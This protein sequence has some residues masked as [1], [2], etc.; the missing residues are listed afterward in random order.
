MKKLSFKRLLIVSDKEKIAREERLET[1]EI[2]V[3]SQGVNRTGK[4]SFIKSLYAALGADPQR[5]NAKWEELQVKLL[6]EFSIDNISYFALR[7]GRHLAFFDANQSLIASYN[8]VT[9]ASEFWGKVFDAEISLPGARGDLIPPMPAA[10]FMPFYIDQDTGLSDTW[11]SFDGLAAYKSYKTTLV[12]FH[13]GAKPKEYYLA[14][15]QKSASA[16]ELKERENEHAHLAF[17]QSKLGGRTIDSDIS[18]NPVDFE[19]QI[20][21]FL[22]QQNA[23]NKLREGVRQE[24]Y[25]L[26]GERRKLAQE[27]SLAAATLKE[28]DADVAYLQ[29]ID[30]SEIVCPTCNTVHETSFANTLRLSADA[31]T[32]RDYLIRTKEQITKVDANIEKKSQTLRRYD[33]EIESIQDILNE[34]RGELSLRSLLEHESRKIAGETLE[35]EKR[36]IEGEIGRIGLAI[37]EVEKSMRKISGT[38]RRKEIIDFYQKKLIEFCQDLNLPSPTVKALSSLRPALDDTGS[39]LPR[40]I[41]AYHYA[42]LHT[43]CEFSSSV[44]APIVFDTAQHQ[45]QDNTNLNAIIRFAF[46]KR[47]KGTQFIFGTVELHDYDFNGRVILSPNERS[48][49]SEKAYPDAVSVIAPFVTAWMS[50]N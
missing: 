37:S 35:A 49:L 44:V 13:S 32:C 29:K 22:R 48:L 11:S 7:V 20:A 42:I 39:D 24:I 38:K 36:S 33:A 27:T 1:D 21:D 46:E 41:L 45:D 16:N 26:Q 4:S 10:W 43:I 25:A 2:V 50:D 31:E 6:L 17:A 3:T 8:G 47:P 9:K 40:L 12:D 34:R 15:A 23:F 14:Q 28:L 18:F 30:T 19:S 5:K